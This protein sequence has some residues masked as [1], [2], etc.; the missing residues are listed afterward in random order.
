MLVGPPGG[1][2]LLLGV[3]GPLADVAEVHHA[4]AGPAVV[5]LGLRVLLKHDLGE[6]PVDVGDLVLA[7]HEA[8]E[9]DRPLPPAAPAAVRHPAAVPVLDQPPQV[10]AVLDVVPQEGLLLLRLEVEHEQQREPAAHL[11]DGP[12]VA[13]SLVLGLVALEEVQFHPRPA[14][15]L[16]RVLELGGIGADPQVGHLLGLGGARQRQLRQEVAPQVAGQVDDLVAVAVSRA[17]GV[18]RHR[19]LEAGQHRVGPDDVLARL[20]EADRGDQRVA[21]LHR[22]RQAGRER[23]LIAIVVHPA[24]VA[25]GEALHRRIQDGPVAAVVAFVVRLAG[26]GIGDLL[27]V[28]RLGSNHGDG[29]RA[30]HVP[31]AV[32]EAADAGG[33]VEGPR[34][35][36]AV[37]ARL[38]RQ[39]LEL[40]GRGG[41]VLGVDDHGKRRLGRDD[42]G[43]DAA[44]RRGGRCRRLLLGRQQGRSGQAGQEDRQ[45]SDAGCSHDPFHGD[46]PD[47]DGH[48]AE[49]RSIFPFSRAPRQSLLGPLLRRTE[50]LFRALPSCRLGKRPYNGGHWHVFR[51]SFKSFLEENCDARSESESV[52]G[53]RTDPHG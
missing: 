15:G 7:Q 48:R 10:Q 12:A 29:H 47:L 31:V 27:A 8:G 41:V 5:V 34:H 42:V 14:E 49:G 6:A 44:G 4:G 16:L 23:W 18:R 46:S 22:D 39:V 3:Q 51:E 50:F 17:E 1:R 25:G 2:G 28:E 45:V 33:L 20:G 43:G 53:R 35:A 37:D 40:G 13:A 32:D 26:L 38:E 11:G 30:H 19:L 24:V 21:R 52:G 9:D 36:V